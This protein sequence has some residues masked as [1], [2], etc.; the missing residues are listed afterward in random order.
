MVV[1]VV[2]DTKPQARVAETMQYFSKLS[3]PT[4]TSYSK[5]RRHVDPIEQTSQ[6]RAC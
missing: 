1:D 5:G 4:R 2:D 3:T 6:K